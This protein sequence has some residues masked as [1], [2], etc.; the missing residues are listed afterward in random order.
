M[1]KKQTKNYI[2]KIIKSKNIIIFV[3]LMVFFIDFSFSFEISL[4]DSIEKI[5][6]TIKR[7]SEISIG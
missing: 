1:F 5:Q 2:H 7:N 6:N 3:F 4:K